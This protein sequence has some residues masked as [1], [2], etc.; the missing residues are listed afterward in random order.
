MENMSVASVIASFF[1]I[2]SRER[3]LELETS[4]VEYMFTTFS[5]SEIT[6]AVLWNLNFVRKSDLV[7]LRDI[8][9][10]ILKKQDLGGSE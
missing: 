2:L 8:Q 9:Y 1:C 5:L 10:V 7:F 6:A 3:L 4:Q